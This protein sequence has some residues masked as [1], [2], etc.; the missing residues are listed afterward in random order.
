MDFKELCNSINKNTCVISVEKKDDSYGEI[1]I[2]TGNDTY[3][4]TF[5]ANSFIPNSLYT[6][7]IEKNLNFEE[8]CYRSAVKKELLQS[9]AYPEVFKAWFHMLFIPIDYNDDNKY[10]CLYV[11]EINDKFDSNKLSSIGND[12]ANKVLK[13]TIKLNNNTDFKLA[14]NKVISDIRELCMASFCCILLID[15]IKE[16]VEVLAES[17][18]DSSDRLTMNDY[19]NRNNF[20]ELATSWYDTL[21][22][23][24]CIIINNNNGMD[25]IKNK[26]IKWYESLVKDKIKSLV[27][28]PLKSRNEL[29]GYI[30]ASNFK[31]DNII[32]IKETLELTT[33]I[34]GSEIG[35]YLSYE[36][37]KI[38]SSIDLLTGVYNRNEM[39]NYMDDLKNRDIKNIGLLFFDVNGLKKVNDLCGHIE[40]DKLIKRASKTLKSIFKNNKIFRCGGDEFVVIINDTNIND[41]DNY[42]EMTFELGIKNNVS[43]AIGY[44]I[45]ESS[46]DI[47]I[48]LKEADSNMYIDKRKY[49]ELIEDGYEE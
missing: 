43:F 37:L 29:I 33:F 6:D 40:G 22:D 26:N 20:Y 46:K 32:E 7:I 42:K 14:L 30:W 10:Y 4:N 27:L 44:S 1:R 9:Y 11:M 36:K 8:Y 12:V 35:N 38:V 15:E 5:K 18:D 17:K 23:N 49:Y 13:T 39:N 34:L 31:S 3:L 19:M 45:K 25:L 48:A 24:N 41:L 21:G 28:F 16:K 2:V 47:F